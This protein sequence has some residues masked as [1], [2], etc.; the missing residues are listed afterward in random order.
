MRTNGCEP[1]AYPGLVCLGLVT[2]SSVAQQAGLRDALKALP[3]VPNADWP[4]LLFALCAAVLGF[5]G[6]WCLAKAL[7]SA[8]GPGPAESEEGKGEG[9]RGD[10]PS[11]QGEDPCCWKKSK[12]PS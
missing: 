4:L 6:L 1:S 10:L 3:D 7:G 11:D 8:C 2:R 9:T 5:L 12:S